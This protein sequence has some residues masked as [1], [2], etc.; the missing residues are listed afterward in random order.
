[1]KNLL[2]EVMKRAWE[3]KKEDN[4]NIFS[5]CLQMAWKEV[6]NVV[7]NSLENVKKL[8]ERYVEDHGSFENGW[9]TK[10]EYNPWEKYGKKRTYIEI[11][12]YRNFALRT[13]K[14]AGYWD[15]NLN[16]YVADNKC[17]KN[18]DLLAQ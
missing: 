11:K 5:I 13:V 1:M 18:I 9:F 6:K 2:S 7:Q 8:A 16:E 4:R 14:K 10:V 12:E 3:I 15:H 17:T